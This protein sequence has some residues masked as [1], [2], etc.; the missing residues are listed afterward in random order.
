MKFNPIETDRLRLRQVRES[1]AASVAALVTPSVSQWTATWPPALSVEGAH[2]RL[3]S[4]IE[5]ER[6]G[7]AMVFAIERKSD[8]VL[9]GLSGVHRKKL[10]DKRCSFGYWLGEAFHGKGYMSEAAAEI[11]RLTWSLMD[12]DVIEAGAQA[13]NI[14]SI[15]I[16]RK[17]GMRCIGTRIEYAPVRNRDEAC[18]YFEI[19][20]P[21]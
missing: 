1:D 12:V 5:H 21:T 17:L 15:A 20:R 9:L 10:E 2:R 13:G 11:I 4:V 19:S 7:L 18:V 14:A 16:L 6:L 3:K 8:D